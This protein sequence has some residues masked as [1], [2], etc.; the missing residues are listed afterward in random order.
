M[1]RSSRH[2]P[3]SLLFPCLCCLLAPV[4]SSPV[5]VTHL[6][7]F[8]GPLPFSL[9]TGYV[10]VD[11]SNGVHLFYYFVESEKDPARDPLV[12]WMQG[13]PGCSGLLGLAYEMGPFKFDVEGYRGGLP[14]L[15]YRPETWTKLSNVIF[16]DS[17]IGAGFS[18]ATSEEGLKSSDTTAVKKLVIFLKKW[19]H[20]HPQFLSNPLYVGG[21]SYCGITIPTLALEIDIS[22]KESG[23]EP[24]LN[25]KGYFAGN[26]STDARFDVAGNIQFFYGMGMLSDELYETAK[27]NCRGNY[28]DPPNALCAESIQAI[29]NCTKD[30]NWSHVLEPSCNVIR[31]PKIQQAA[32]KSGTSGLMVEYS[33]DDDI[34]FPFKCRGDTL[35]LSNIWAND[36]RV[37]KSLGVRKGTK[38]EWITCDHGI[39]F[40]RDI[41]STIEIHLRLRREG[42]PALIFSGDHDSGVSFVG[43]QAW[44][45]SLNLSITDDWRPWYV[46]GQV[47]G[48]T[49]SFSS[50]LTYA[51]VKGAGHTTPEYKPKECLAMFTRW[52]SGDPL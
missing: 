10:E 24:L 40:T 47:A 38:G 46:D 28:S 5:A 44:I 4:A 7:G 35:E 51:T 21:E 16:I 52:I 6:P 48:F 8:D 18:Y 41:M 1:A 13:G 15:L 25:L 39:P 32:V 30:I 33:A 11:E 49:R 42:Y 14:T 26:P 31:S 50:N 9:E 19:L 17:P 43:T 12:L 27:E 36:E 20:E 34:P 29:A 2:F 45:R 23:D 37:R 3:W 22:N